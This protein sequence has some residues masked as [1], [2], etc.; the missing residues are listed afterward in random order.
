MSNYFLFLE[1]SRIFESMALI[2][3]SLAYIKNCFYFCNMKKT[4][5]LWKSH[6]GDKIEK[7]RFIAGI[8]NSIPLERWTETDDAYSTALGNK[9]IV[10][11]K[12][13]HILPRIEINDCDFGFSIVIPDMVTNLLNK[14]REFMR[15][16][17]EELYEKKLDEIYTFFNETT[18]KTS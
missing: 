14:L 12:T 4:G 9:K 2:I 1:S 6:F 13:V 11:F 7:I 5:E 18:P 10:L 3:L 15:Q 8:I 16:K 17:K